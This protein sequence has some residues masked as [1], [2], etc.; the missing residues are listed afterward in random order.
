[1]VETELRKIKAKCWYRCVSGFD[2]LGIALGEG[3][4]MKVKEVRARAM[5]I[6]GE[7]D[8]VEQGSGAQTRKRLEGWE[9][10]SVAMTP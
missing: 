6:P 7:Q 3:L 8:W 4:R 10:A 5:R 1:M 2:I 9:E